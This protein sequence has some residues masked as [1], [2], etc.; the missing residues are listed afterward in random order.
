MA[1]APDPRE[2]L[3][4]DAEVILLKQHSLVH[5]VRTTTL[6]FLGPYLEQDWK[7]FSTWYSQVGLISALDVRD[8]EISQLVTFTQ[9]VDHDIP[10]TVERTLCKHF[11]C[12]TLDDIL[13]LSE[14]ERRAGLVLLLS[15]Y[16]G[17]GLVCAVERLCG[18]KNEE[19]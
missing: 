17:A 19:P 18:L 12:T 7:E 9:E 16:P 3:G 1:P 13:E 2:R 5:G 8:D 10:W 11:N 4:L 14:E 15:E 6:R